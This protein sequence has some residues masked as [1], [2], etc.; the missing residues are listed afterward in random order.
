VIMRK[1]VLHIITATGVGGAENMLYKY[2]SNSNKDYIEHS[3]ISLT[4]IDEFGVKIKEL[5]IPVHALSEPIY[6]L[7]GMKDLYS[8]AKQLKPDVLQS[9]LYHSDLVAL[10]LN[11]LL[12]S[13][14]CWNIRSYK[15]FKYKRST[16]MLVR[17]LALFSKVPDA[18]IINSVASKNY[19]HKIWY[20]PNRWEY[21]PNGFDADVFKQKAEFKN[22]IRAELD[23][24]FD[25]NIIGMVARYSAE[26]DHE[27]FLRACSLIHK[28][29]PSVHF[30]MVGYG[31]DQSNLKLTNII[32]ELDL[33]DCV[34]LLGVRL[35]VPAIVPC[36]DIACS[37][38]IDEAFPNVI[39]EAMTA[40]V[41]CVVTDV[42]DCAMVVADT[43]RVVPLGDPK[44]ISDACLELLRL[45]ETERRDLGYQARIRAIKE[46]SIQKISAKYDDIYLSL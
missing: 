10:I 30:V 41:P 43:G 1:K 25:A 11:F 35:D 22:D 42:G 20:R 32:D 44:Y 7:Q 39:G 28:A 2:L 16:G 34:H 3:V 31:V 40:A 13:K 24:V 9:W 14:L 29:L 21:V 26:K 37:S 33:H 6:T 4:G 45:P 15:V 12:K 18:V 46:F 8:V 38:S 19:H 27:S 36:F 23:I 5:K 17:L